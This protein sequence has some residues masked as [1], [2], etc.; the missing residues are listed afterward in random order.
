MQISQRL[1]ELLLVGL[2]TD[3]DLASDFA[4][5][6]SISLESPAQFTPE[7]NNSAL[8]SLYLYQI[9]SNTHVNNRPPVS[10]GQG[11]QLY[12]SLSLNLS[13][14]LTPMHSSAARC[15]LILGRAMQSLAAS[16]I[17]RANFLDS[18]RRPAAPEVRLTLN[19]ITMEEIARIW[20]ALNEPYRLS[21]C[22]QVQV[23]SIDSIRPP[24]QESLVMERLLDIHQISAGNGGTP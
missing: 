3:E 8:L 9:S 13:Y 1:N 22:Y 14:L 19:P 2:R 18:D 17:I 10:S 5:E 15:Q 21:V 11:E 20:N 24:E 4:A 23:V 7:D 16:P 6:A 12:P